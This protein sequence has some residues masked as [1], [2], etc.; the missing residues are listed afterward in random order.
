MKAIVY[1][2]NEILESVR[3]LVEDGTLRTTK[4]EHYGKINAENL[5]RA[6]GFIESGRARG[7]IVLEGF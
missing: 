4:G 7:K 5:R 6:H 3:R 2:Q 1:S